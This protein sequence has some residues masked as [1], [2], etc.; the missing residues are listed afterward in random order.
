MR[1]L[2]NIRIDRVSW[3]CVAAETPAGVVRLFG[4]LKTGGVSDYRINHRL[5]AASPLGSVVNDLVLRWIMLDV[6][7]LQGERN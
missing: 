1:P 4:A 3:F 2:W 7:W 5:L 6:S